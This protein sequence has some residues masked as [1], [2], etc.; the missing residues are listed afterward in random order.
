M[1]GLGKR[2]QAMKRL[3][4]DQQITQT[5]Q[6]LLVGSRRTTSTSTNSETSNFQ[7]LASSPLCLV[8]D[9]NGTQPQTSESH[10]S[11]Q[12]EVIPISAKNESNHTIAENETNQTVVDGHN[13]NDNESI[14]TTEGHN[15]NGMNSNVKMPY[16]YAL[17]R[18]RGI[19]R[20]LSLTKKRDAKEVLTI[21]V[22]DNVRRIVG[23]D[24]QHFI[25][26][27]GCVLWKLAKLNVQKW[28]KLSDKDREDLITLN[29]IKDPLSNAIVHK[30]TNSQYRNHQYGLHKLFLRYNTKEEA[31]EHVPKGVSQNDW[32]WL[33]DYFSS[34]QFQKR[35]AVE[36]SEIELFEFSQH[37]KKKGGLVN[38]KAK[39]TLIKEICEKEVGYAPGQPRP[40][41]FQLFRAEIEKH[42]KRADAAEAQ[43]IAI[44][45]QFNAQQE[46]IKNLEQQQRGKKKSCTSSLL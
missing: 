4:E 19:T 40:S 5:G 28:S 32:I 33:C 7:T 29:M 12:N 30:Q 21:D 25:T 46:T 18:R 14:Q 41:N 23:K 45:E 16:S 35:K 38:D 44:I 24:S 13:A 10:A 2:G 36:L 3:R 39:E 26:E 22:N 9:D 6:D 42:M 37:S 11:R 31:M 17:L 8:S 20:N 1:A 27:S 15:G 34:A 43:T